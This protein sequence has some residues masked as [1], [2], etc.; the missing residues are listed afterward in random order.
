MQIEPYIEEGQD[1]LDIEYVRELKKLTI[2][3]IEERIV[4]EKAEIPMDIMEGIEIYS[5]KGRCVIDYCYDA[6]HIKEKE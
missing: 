1:Y 2:D 4:G 3:I 5:V 6:E